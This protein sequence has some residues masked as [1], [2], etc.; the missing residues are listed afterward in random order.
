MAGTFVLT[1][2]MQVVKREIEVSCLK[3][4][5]PLFYRQTYSH[6]SSLPDAEGSSKPQG[7]KAQVHPVP[8]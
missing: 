4:Q 2:Q 5:L 1:A 7:N 8:N 3:V 6:D